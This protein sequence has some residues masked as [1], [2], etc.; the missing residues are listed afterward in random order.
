MLIDE[1]ARLHFHE[2]QYLG[3]KDLELLQAYLR[4]MRRRHNVAH[5]TWGIVVGL[6]LVERINECDPTTVDV[7]I[8]PGLAID[9]FGRETIVAAPFKLEPPLFD[10]FG[11]LQHRAIW[12]THDEERAGRPGYGYEVC[13]DDQFSRVREIFRVAADP[14]PPTHDPLVVAGKVAVPPVVPADESAPYQEFPDETAHPE[15]LIRLGSVNWDGV[16]GRLRPAAPGKLI[17]GRRYVSIVAEQLLAP[18]ASLKLRGRNNSS[19]LPTD[20]TKPDYPGIAAEVEGS[21]QIDRLTTAKQDV[22]IHGGRL[23]FMDKDGKDDGIPLWM[24]RLLGPAGAG[25]DDL[26]IHIGDGKIGDQ[27][28][29]SARLTVGNLDPTGKKE[30]VIFDVKGD[31]TV[32]IPTGVLDF[33]SKLRQMMNLWTSASGQHLHGI[34]VQGNTTYFRT[35]AE[36]AWFEKGIHNDNP[37]NPGGGMMQL[38]LN[39]TGLFF[40][41]R[42]RQMLNLW[43]SSFGIGI[44]DGTLY[45]RSGQDFCWF[46]GG[47]HIDLG[48]NAGPGGVIA[49]KLDGTSKLNVTG[50]VEI[51]G[52]LRVAGNQ[53]LIRIR[54]Y[55]VVASN[56]GI[57]SPATWQVNYPGDFAAIY[58]GFAMLTGFS[59]FSPSGPGNHDMSFDDIVQQVFVDVAQVN[60]KEA[61]G[62]CYCSQSNAAF[63]ASNTVRF[64]LVVI[65]KEVM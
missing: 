56:A 21:L 54:K 52:N 31:D 22:Q 45:F 24:Q 62:T 20:P 26:R 43:D 14:P 11:N 55:E 25:S 10:A 16:N 23:Y 58:T 8:S 37:V 27:T 3:A 17:E 1:V 57:D 6:D 41:S 30:S 19:P 44:Q 5:H 65:G 47:S 53:N 2:R 7:F 60:L 49:L 32:D 35:S 51:G 34:G 9:G 42:T 36:F 59:V 63:E 39:D 15:W 48:S 50:D 18:A 64:T 29:A 40:G 13:E 33:G 46:R 12:I 28:S 61:H 4:D 38:R